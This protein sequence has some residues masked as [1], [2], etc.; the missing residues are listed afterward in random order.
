M[1][2]TLGKAL[3]GASGGRKR[4][5]EIGTSEAAKQ[6]I[7]FQTLAPAIAGASLEVIKML[8]DR[9]QNTGTWSMKTH[10]TSGKRWKRSDFDLLPGTHP[11][12][13]IMLYDARIASEFSASSLIKAF[14]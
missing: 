12:V 8:G 2:G 4:R 14:T 10:H 1:T 11:I 3:G 13:P 5:E 6:H 7:F 9:L